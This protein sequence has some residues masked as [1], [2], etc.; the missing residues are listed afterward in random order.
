MFVVTGR[1]K[2]SIILSMLRQVI[3]LIPCLILFGWLW[4]LDGVLR[5][6]PVADG[7]SVLVTAILIFFELKKLKDPKNPE[8]EG[9]VN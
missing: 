9:L 4:G 1:P 3:V 5:A 6:T 2:V 8:M 7:V